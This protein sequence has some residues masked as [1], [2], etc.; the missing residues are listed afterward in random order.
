[1]CSNT[2][3][4]S[5]KAALEN[6]GRPMPLGEK[7]RLIVSNTLLKLTKRRS[8]CGNHGQPGC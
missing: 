5:A 2:G 7:L 1:M 3:K 6:L 4:P 8:C